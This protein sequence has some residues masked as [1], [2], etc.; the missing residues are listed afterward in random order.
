MPSS[1]P[2]RLRASFGLLCLSLALA[3]PLTAQLSLTLEQAIA[4]ASQE[5][6]SAMEAEATLAAARY[7]DRARAS[8]ELPQ[9]SLSGTL[10]SYRRSISPIT[11]PDGSV[12]Y[13]SQ[14]YTDASLSARLTQTLPFSG[15]EVYLQSSLGRLGLSGLDNRQLWNATPFTVG[16]SQSLF[17][18]NNFAWDR[19]DAALSLEIAEQ[20]YLEARED[21][22]L[23]VTDLF[24]TAYI[25]ELSYREAVRTAAVNDTL[26]ARNVARYEASR[27]GEADK[28]A[29]EVQQL[30][31]QSR[32]EQARMD[33]ERTRA[34]LLLEL[35]LP[36]DQ[37]VNL[38]VPSRVP[39]F[40]VDT[41]LA[42]EEAV[43]N[44]TTPLALEQ[45][46][47]QTERALNSARFTNG[48]M[49]NFSASMGV[50]GSADHLGGAYDQTQRAQ[51]LTLSLS[52]PLL[53]YG[54]RSNTIRAAAA[55]QQRVEQ[56]TSYAMA[57]AAQDAHYAALQVPLA[58]RSLEIAVR[59]DSAAALYFQM[60][61][62]LY[63]NGRGSVDILYNAQ[64]QQQQ[65]ITNR[66]N[67]LRGFWVAYYQLRRITLYDFARGQKI[68][69]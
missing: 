20:R 42:V 63:S 1:S 47:L 30:M 5:G 48:I 26:L 29:S 3:F 25:A 14:D 37:Q 65:A 10:P 69:M 61:Y 38:V 16:I 49:A 24:F 68:E 55:D 18:P 53:Q 52:M 27:I 8:R 2:L 62:N 4:R 39:D 50:N 6:H 21:L 57:Q 40:A 28:L 22:A 43:R 56:S 32:V 12:L 59:A 41:L 36:M 7:R 31:A 15:G 58:R 51:Q 11:Q 35:S 23:R 13:R 9:L 17:A 46:R 67:A 64:T 60:Q 34:A 54:Q 33:Q 44:G 19:R 66:L 45:Q